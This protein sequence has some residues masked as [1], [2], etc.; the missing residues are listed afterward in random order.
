MADS[1]SGGKTNHGLDLLT[2]WCK[3]S[4]LSCSFF[5]FATLNTAMVAIGADALK[6]CKVEPMIP[7]YLIGKRFNFQTRIKFW[8]VLENPVVIRCA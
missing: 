8:I 7:I 4:G 2:N 3:K 6:L 5:I 1:V